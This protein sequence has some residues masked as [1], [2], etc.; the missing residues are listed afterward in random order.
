M[1]YKTPYKALDISK[2]IISNCMAESHAITNLQLQKILYFLQRKY[3]VDYD[4]MLFSDEIQAW[5]SGSV[6]PEVD[7]HFCGFGSMRITTN[8]DIKILDEDR[9][10]IDPIVEEK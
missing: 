2:Y 1:V 7:Y 6:V 9:Q 4:T 3:L 10:I 5:L 8:D